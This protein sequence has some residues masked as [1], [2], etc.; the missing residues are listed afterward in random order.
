M[1]T[2][3]NDGKALR[4]LYDELKIKYNFIR[5]YIHQ[6]CRND[7]DNVWRIIENNLP[8]LLCLLEGKL[9][10]GDISR[11]INNGLDLLSEAEEIIFKYYPSIH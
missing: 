1:E 9:V 11:D 3:I 6:E 7:Y 10:F 2:A 5:D 4:E 8:H